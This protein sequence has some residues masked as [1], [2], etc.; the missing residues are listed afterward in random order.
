MTEEKKKHKSGYAILRTKLD[1]R[2]TEIA[3]LK[4]RLSESNVLKLEEEI[5]LWK[6]RHN[7]MEQKNKNL[8]ESLNRAIAQMGRF[9]RLIY[10]Y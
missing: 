8:R 7:A 3:E 10:H 5:A 2:D 6:N 4:E 1:K 9:R